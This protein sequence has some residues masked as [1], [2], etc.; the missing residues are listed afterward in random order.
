MP[1][2]GLGDCFCR[3]LLPSVPA[4]L[5]LD[6]KIFGHKLHQAINFFAEQVLMPVW[7][8]QAVVLYTSL[9]VVSN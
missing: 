3:L 5:Q 9:S 4:D 7:S 1:C 2:Q 8:H 6:E